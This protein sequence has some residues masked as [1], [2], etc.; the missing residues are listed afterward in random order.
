MFQYVATIPCN[1]SLIACFLALMFRNVVW[2]HM[3][4]VAGL[5]IIN[6]LQI[7]LRTFQ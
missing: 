2:Q 7:Y 3:Q 5:L 6:L 4:L 1:L